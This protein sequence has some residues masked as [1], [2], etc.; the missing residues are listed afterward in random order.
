MSAVAL[1]LAGTLRSSPHTTVAID[2][3]SAPEIV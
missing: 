3:K 1:I 2:P